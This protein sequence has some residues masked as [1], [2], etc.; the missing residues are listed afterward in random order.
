MLENNYLIIA[1]VSGGLFTNS[2]TALV[3]SLKKKLLKL[4]ENQN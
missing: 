1:S 3:K 4:I 2:F